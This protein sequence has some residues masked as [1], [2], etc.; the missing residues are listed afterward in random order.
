MWLSILCL[1]FPFH[2]WSGGPR[3]SPHPTFQRKISW[4][5][6]YSHHL[7][8]DVNF[9]CSQAASAFK[10]LEPSFRQTLISQ[11]FK[12]RVYSQTIQSILLHGSESQIY[13]PYL[14]STSKNRLSPLHKIFQVKS[15]YTTGI[16]V[17]CSPQIS[18]DSLVRMRFFSLYHTQF[19]IPS[20]MRISDARIKYLG[21]ILPHPNCP[22]FL[23]CF[24]HSL[25]LR[26]I[27]ASFR[28]GAPR[29]HWPEITLAEAPLRVQQY[30]HSPPHVRRL[31]TLLVSS[32]HYCQIQAIF[33]HQ[34]E[35]VVQYYPMHPPPPNFWRQGREIGNQA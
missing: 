35:A 16:T 23:P 9:R 27:S 17:Y 22:N 19:C 7:C 34:Y 20:S 24:N 26:A 25:S 32:F 5:L 2:S 10:T 13:S 18:S 12:L 33:P 28:R 14:S 6:Y 15:P 31:S 30:R 29:A 21:H 4:L 8:P 11:K 3:P 1:F